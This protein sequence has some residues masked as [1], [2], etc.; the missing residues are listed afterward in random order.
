MKQEESVMG[1][2]PLEISGMAKTI[3][4]IKILVGGVEARMSI[5]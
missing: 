2:N 3:V 1:R 4:E 5:S